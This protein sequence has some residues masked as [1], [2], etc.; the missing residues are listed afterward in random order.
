MVCADRSDHV[1]VPRA[2]DAGHFRSERLGDLH[3]E[4]THASR[5][6]IDQDLLPW[7]HLSRIAKTVKG[8]DCGGR[9]GRGL[10]KR[11]VGRLQHELVFSST[12]ILG[13]GA[14]ARAENLITWL[15]PLHVLAGRLN[16][17]CHIVSRNVV[18]WFGPPGTHAHEVRHASH[19]EVVTCVEGSRVNAYQHVVFLDHRLVD[20]LEFEDIR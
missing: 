4:R 8:G 10:L 5:R 14:R 2:A 18:L 19:G 13:A 15:N 1:H 12:H 17:P 7:L 11:E 9:Y 3:G 6:T 20:L 16:L